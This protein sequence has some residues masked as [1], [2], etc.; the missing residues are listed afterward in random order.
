MDQLEYEQ[1]LTKADKYFAQGKYKMFL[2]EFNKCY[3]FNTDC[4]NNE[5]NIFKFSLSNYSLTNNRTINEFNRFI[6]LLNQYLNTLD[7]TTDREDF[8]IKIKNL[9]DKKYNEVCLYD[10]IIYVEN[11]NNY[12]A[13]LTQLCSLTSKCVMEKLIANKKTIYDFIIDIETKIKQLFKIIRFTM[14]KYKI[15]FIYLPKKPR[16]FLK[17]IEKETLNLKRIIDLEQ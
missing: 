2:D 15:H 10:K 11:F 3:A 1:L 5:N 6:P 9:I 8:I 12:C 13:L 14:S 7:N 16:R 4:F 17:D